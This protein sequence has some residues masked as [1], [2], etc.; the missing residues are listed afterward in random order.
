MHITLDRN[1][2][3]KEIAELCDCAQCAV[4]KTENM[5]EMN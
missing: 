5:C 2:I 4:L 1:P 3:S